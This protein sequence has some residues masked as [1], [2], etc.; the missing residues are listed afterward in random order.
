MVLRLMER[1][2]GVGLHGD[3]L[4]A[5]TEVLEEGTGTSENRRA[6]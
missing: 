6:A 3:C 5:L 2:R 4:D 1:D